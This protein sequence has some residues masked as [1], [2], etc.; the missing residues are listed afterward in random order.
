MEHAL[1]P[2][3]FVQII[4]I[5][6]DD[7]EFVPPFGIETGERGVGGVGFDCRQR[8]A[9]GIVE[10]EDKRAIAGKRFGRADVFDPVAFP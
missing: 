4:D 10:F 6:G 9:S 5:L 2:C 3:P 7:Q 1:R 8:G